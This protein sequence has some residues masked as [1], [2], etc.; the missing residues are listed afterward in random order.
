[1]LDFGPET[2][3][4]LNAE[5]YDFFHDPGTTEISVERI[6]EVAGSGKILELAIGTGRIALPLLQKGFDVA[7]IEGSPLM[8]EK[9][10]EKPGGDKIDVVIGDF[11]DVN[12]DG[13]YD[14][15]CLVFNTLFNLPSQDAQLRCLANSAK[16]LKLGG[17]FLVETFVPDISAFTN[18]Q[19]VST[20]HLDRS[21]VVIE[22]VVHDP[23]L[24]TFEFQRIQ[25][26][27]NGTRLV[28]LP[29]RYAYPPEL[30]LMAKLA[31]LRLRDRWGGWNKEPFTSDSKMHVSVYE[32][33][34]A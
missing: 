14:H 33:A 16:R 11:A 22:A 27:E 25:F 9:L 20:R 5:G 6:A 7:G 1:M 19:R 17:T 13:I 4:E 12:I 21:S 29:M 18:H 2:F 26:T 34:A 30:D 10:R 28:P 24:Q 15:V 31:G 32:K 8:V 3:G 23:V